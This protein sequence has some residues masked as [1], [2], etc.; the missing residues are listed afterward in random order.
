M[1]EKHP[2]PEKS[3]LRWFLA[4]FALAIPHGVLAAYF[5]I[6]QNPQGESCRYVKDGAPYHLIIEG[7]P[8]VLTSMIFIDLGYALLLWAPAF[9]TI[10]GI[11]FIWNWFRKNRG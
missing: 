9:L 1:I 6:V 8:C 2:Q 11:V 7:E 3:R 10:Y 5:G 4:Y